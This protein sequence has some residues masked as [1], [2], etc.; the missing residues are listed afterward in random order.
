M[1]GVTW[2]AP[3]VASSTESKLDDANQPQDDDNDDNHADDPD[4]TAS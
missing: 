3:K 1:G 4:A 2:H